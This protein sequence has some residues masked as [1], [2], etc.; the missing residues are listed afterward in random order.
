MVNTAQTLNEEG[1]VVKAVPSLV[2]GDATESP[3]ILL[4]DVPDDEGPA[5]QEMNSGVESKGMR[6]A[7]SIPCD[8]IWDGTGNV[9]SQNGVPTGYRRHV[10]WR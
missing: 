5:S 6:A 8:V 2:S 7:G 9:T 10:A 4:T 3:G 1:N